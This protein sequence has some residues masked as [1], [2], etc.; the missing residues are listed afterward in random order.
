[1]SDVRGAARV[2]SNVRRMR[3]NAA[4]PLESIGVFFMS[5]LLMAVVCTW[6]WDGFVNGRLYY[7]TDGGTLDFLCVGD[8][9]HH[10][11]SVAHVVARSVDQPEE[12][13]SGWSI[14]GLGCLWG[15]FVAGSVLVSAL[16]AGALWRA[17]SPNVT[18]RATAA[19]IRGLRR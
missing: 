18:L 7:C 19:E 16:F 9:V 15:A 2:S 14:T 4:T 8:W 17:S 1:M 6:A 10:P 12:I 11:E 3:A 13:K 5:M